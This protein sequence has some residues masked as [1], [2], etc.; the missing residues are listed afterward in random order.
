MTTRKELFE[1]HAEDITKLH[2]GVQALKFLKAYAANTM[3][4]LLIYYVP[5]FVSE[6][7]E[8]S[9]KVSIGPF[10]LVDATMFGALIE[11]AERIKNHQKGVD[12]NNA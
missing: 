2:R 4:R 9:W 5:P 6:G 3:N 8:G 11:I 7:I 1:D 12:S 10:E